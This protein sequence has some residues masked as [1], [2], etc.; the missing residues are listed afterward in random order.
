MSP[1]VIARLCEA[2]FDRG[3]GTY[4]MGDAY[5]ATHKVIHAQGNRNMDL[6]ARAE[7]CWEK[8]RSSQPTFSMN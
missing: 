8:T 5:Q 2:I 7:R 6:C 4:R 3:V 1:I